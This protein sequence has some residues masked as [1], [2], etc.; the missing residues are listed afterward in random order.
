MT[1][2]PASPPPAP[3]SGWLSDA[4][5]DPPWATLDD[6][7]FKA[8]D[9]FNSDTDLRLMPVVDTAHR[10]I[11]AIFEKDVRRLLL[12]PF[13][14]ALL[15]NPYF[16]HGV[17]RHVR[18][19]PVAE[20]DTGIG[21]LIHAYRRAGGS[22]GMILTRN[23]RLAGVIGNRRLLLLAAEYERTSA[24]G[25]VARAERIERASERFEGEVASLAQALGDLSAML[26]HSAAETGH[27]ATEVGERAV[28]VASA[29]S[30]TSD[31]MREIAAR[32]RD[33]AAS[34]E[35]VEG[36]TQAAEAAA[37]KVSALVRAGSAR[38]RELHRAA[39][40]VDSVIALISDIAGQ[41]N[42]LAL[43]ATIEAARAGEAGRGFTV[44]A[45]EVKQLSNQ[46]G[47]AAGR[48]TAHVAEIRRGIDDVALGH[49]Q[50]EEA[51]ASMVDLAAGVQ[52]AIAAQQAATHLIARNVEEAVGASNAIRHDVEAIGGTS[53]TASSSAGDMH[54]LA[55]RLQRDAGTLS[56]ELGA[57]LAELRSA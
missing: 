42:L 24:A 26:Q 52:G 57:F 43:N 28:A 25:R 6:S 45:N 35:Q 53:R 41:V 16:G 37:G 15:R 3:N 38:T 32:G 22:E 20:I 2:A 49:M 17:V 46:T 10:P 12:N 31:N 14:H 23:G 33:L 36:N 7:L 30:Q 55:A 13:G 40:T 56:V 19:C 1:V 34:L 48:I 21:A 54:A 4:E 44:V 27:R 5:A 11:G 47:V 18:A 9:L 29:A 8:V 39:Q 50:V 51:I